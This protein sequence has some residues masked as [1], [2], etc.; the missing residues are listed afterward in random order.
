MLPLLAHRMQRAGKDL[1]GQY[2]PIV[3][4]FAAEAAVKQA[5]ERFERVAPDLHKVCK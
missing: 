1:L 2:T 4:F 3:R 5:D